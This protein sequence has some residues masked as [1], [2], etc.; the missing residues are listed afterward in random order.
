MTRLN[1]IDERLDAIRAEI[2]E[3]QELPE[4]TDDDVARTDTLLDE[5]DTLT[6]ERLPLAQ[7]AER[8]EAVRSAAQD[9][10]NVEP[11]FHTPQVVI[12]SDPFENLDALR[13]SYNDKTAPRSSED[14]IARA[15]TAL[16]DNRPRGITDEQVQT[17]VR[18]VETIPGAAHHALI[19]GSP[20]YRSAFG[21]WLA[22]QGQNVVY[23]PEQADAVR[24]AMSLT[25]ANGGYAL[26]TLLDPTLI[27]TGT[28]SKNPIRQISR[29]VSGTQNVWH[30]VSAG[31]V[32]S[33]WTAEAAAMTEGSPTLASPSVTAAKLTAF[34]L[35]SYE[36]FED[37]NLLAELPGLIRESFD[38]MEQDAFISGSGSGAPKGIVT[39]ISGT[40][41]D[42]I[43][44]TT[45]GSVGAVD[46]MALYGSLPSRYEDNATWVAN[47]AL[48]NSVQMFSSGSAGSLFWTDLSH[49]APPMLLG[50]PIVKASA[51]SAATTSGTVV[52]VLGDF[53]QFLIY[54][55]IGTTV[56]FVQNYFNSSAL[57]T[58]QRALIA[59][60]RVGSDVTDVNAFRFLKA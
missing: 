48:Y 12:R 23:T 57:P 53:S 24:T 44:A 34:L 58:G 51:M 4:P 26:P 8:V 40:A 30:G 47:K 38:Y 16:S 55:R 5:R 54:D 18:A 42:T 33:Y 7:R 39:A 11:A 28:A 10:V 25:G 27:H 22:A 29:V 50:F 35:G 49:S 15:V 3:I 37:S 59:H 41:G 6:D 56:E 43:T 2:L 60:K 17:A 21:A 19:H 14:I 52:A 1:E 45:R 31:N 46:I 9:P 36:V 20:A 32:T 13:F